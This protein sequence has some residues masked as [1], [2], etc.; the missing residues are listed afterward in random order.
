MKTQ[1]AIKRLKGRQ[2]WQA[3]LFAYLLH[4]SRGADNLIHY[5]VLRSKLQNICFLFVVQ[6]HN[7]Y[8]D[9]LPFKIFCHEI[10]RLLFLQNYDYSYRTEFCNLVLKTL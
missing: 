5:N 9:I 6:I 7:C 3:R 2:E 8:A 10:F 4:Y 1:E